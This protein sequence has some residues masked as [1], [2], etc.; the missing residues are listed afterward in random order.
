MVTKIEGKA[1]NINIRPS[2]YYRYAHEYFRAYKQFIS[3]DKG[4]T[5]VPYYLICHS[6]ELALKAYLSARGLTNEELRFKSNR[7]RKNGDGHNLPVIY[8]KCKE[9]GLGYLIKTTEAQELSIRKINELYNHKD[10]EYFMDLA[11]ILKKKNLP[12][13]NKLELIAKSLL[14]AINEM[15]K[16]S[17]QTGLVDEFGK[18]IDP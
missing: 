10:F 18:P 6:I 9:M 5:P 12:E 3:Q 7:G 2:G 16:N 1:L 15:I 14:E 11:L 17:C 13:L 8:D 4:F